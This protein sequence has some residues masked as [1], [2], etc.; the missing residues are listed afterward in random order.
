MGSMRRN[1]CGVPEPNA[2]RPERK[3]ALLAEMEPSEYR[4]LENGLIR[5]GAIFGTVY[6]RNAE[7][8]EAL[9]R[10]EPYDPVILGCSEEAVALIRR[11]RRLPGRRTILVLASPE[12]DWLELNRCLAVGADE[13]FG[14][15]YSVRALTHFVYMILSVPEAPKPEDR[16]RRLLEEADSACGAKAHAISVWRC[17]SCTKRVCSR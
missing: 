2:Q 12:T 5:C 3:C 4:M 1:T 7:E 11:L 15:P 10:Q 8:A 6:A 16:C 13:A 14:W 9:C 17:C